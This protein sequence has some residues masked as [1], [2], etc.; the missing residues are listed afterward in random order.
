MP[1]LLTPNVNFLPSSPRLLL[2]KEVSAARWDM[3]ALNEVIVASG[4]NGI[5]LHDTY[6]ARHIRQLIQADPGQA[7][8]IGRYICAMHE[9]WQGT[10]NPIPQPP[11][12]PASTQTKGSLVLRTASALLFPPGPKTLH[13]LA[14]IEAKL[15]RARPLPYVMFP[16]P[17]GRLAADHAKADRFP[18]SRIQPTIDVAAAWGANGA[19]SFIDQLIAR[20]YRVV[21]DTFHGDRKGRMTDVSM[22]WDSLLPHLVDAGFVDQVHVSVGRYD[23]AQTDPHRTKMSEY[24]AQALAGKEGRQ[25]AKTA[26]GD[27]FAYLREQEWEGDV[28]IEAPVSGVSAALGAIATREN[29]IGVHT[30]MTHVVREQLPH[31]T[32][33]QTTALQEVSHSL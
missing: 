10:A 18:Y 21:W 22:R 29:L 28:T 8:Y 13:R 19:K 6:I 9:G 11:F 12:K 20:H 31:I 7:R 30:T 26:L 15:D 23:F 2:G 3:D 27:T 33:D 5:E 17:Q 24:E 25:L 4:Y 16:D 14:A 32:W 1:R